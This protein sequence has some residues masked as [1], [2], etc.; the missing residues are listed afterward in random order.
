MLAFNF[1]TSLL[2]VQST[3]A[4]YYELFDSVMFDQR[5][6]AYEV[7]FVTF[8]FIS[9]ICVSLNGLFQSCPDCKQINK[10]SSL[11]YIK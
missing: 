10:F 2:F 7:L 1:L 11:D 3:F 9:G 8:V 4:I 5:L 6:I